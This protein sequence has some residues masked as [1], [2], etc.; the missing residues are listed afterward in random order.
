MWIFG[1]GR[2]HH[3]ERPPAQ[4]PACGITAQAPTRVFGVE[5]LVG[6][7]IHD[8][9]HLYP[10]SDKGAEVLPVHATFLAATSEYFN[11]VSAEFFSYRIQYITIS[12]DVPK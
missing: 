12:G 3:F 4:N 9:G 1:R 10:T 5:T 8:S 11:P 6:V 7:R 2:D